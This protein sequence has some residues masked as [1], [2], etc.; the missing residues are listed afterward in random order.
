VAV[1]WRVRTV[2]VRVS[3]SLSPLGRCPECCSAGTS[4]TTRDPLPQT[5]MRPSPSP[6]GGPP[7]AG[8]ELGLGGWSESRGFWNPACASGRRGPSQASAWGASATI[9][10]STVANRGSRTGST[11]CSA[12]SRA[13]TAGLYPITP[14]TGPPGPAS[15]PAP[16]SKV[17]AHPE[18]RAQA[19]DLRP[20]GLPVGSVAGRRTGCSRLSPPWGMGTTTPAACGRFPSDTMRGAADPVAA[21]RGAAPPVERCERHGPSPGRARGV[22]RLRVLRVP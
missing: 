22:R 9:P 19:P 21:S 7:G 4:P 3:T 6:A 10:M 5:A 20:R 8:V 14:I 2:Q 11:T 15:S 18:G 1:G 13:T 16:A 17:G 12:S